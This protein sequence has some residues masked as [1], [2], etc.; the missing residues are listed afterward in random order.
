VWLTDNDDVARMPHYMKSIPLGRDVSRVHPDL[1][2]VSHK[3]SKELPGKT[4]S[5]MRRVSNDGDDV[6][7]FMME[8]FQESY[9]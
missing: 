4:S 9:T 7:P 5:R 1:M 8:G 2:R 6:A 3:I